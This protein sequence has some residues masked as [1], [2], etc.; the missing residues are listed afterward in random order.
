MAAVPLKMFVFHAFLICAFKRGVASLT[1]AVSVHQL[2]VRAALH[3]AEIQKSVF[4][5][6]QVIIARDC[7]TGGLAVAVI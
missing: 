6:C 5:V 3:G 4:A 2:W 7:S 1:L